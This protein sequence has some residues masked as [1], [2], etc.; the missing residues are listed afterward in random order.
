MLANV[1]RKELEQIFCQFDSKLEAADE[2][3]RLAARTPRR[4]R[5]RPRPPS[6]G[7]GAVSCRLGLGLT[8]RSSGLRG[9][10]VPPGHVPPAHQPR[11]GQE[12]HP[13]TGGEPFP[14]RGRRPRGDGQDQGRA[15]LLRGHRGKEGKVAGPGG[16]MDGPRWRVCF[17]PAR[18]TPPGGAWVLPPP[19]FCGAARSAVSCW[20]EAFSLSGRQGL[21]RRQGSQTGVWGSDTDG[22]MARGRQVSRCGAWVLSAGRPALHRNPDVC[23]WWPSW[24][25]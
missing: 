16:A 18:D 23:S 15:V 2:V 17:L 8:G 10:E 12:H 5:G 1:I 20:T 11:D 14:P 4:V 25:S 19:R 9:R 3:R 13:V 22:R 7:C 24:L 6:G 21:G